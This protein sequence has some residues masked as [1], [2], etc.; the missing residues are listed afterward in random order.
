[1]SVQKRNSWFSRS[2]ISLSWYIRRMLALSRLSLSLSVH[3]HR[4]IRLT[5]KRFPLNFI[6]VFWKSVGEIQVS[7]NSDN[8]SGTLHEDRCTCVVTS[9]W[10]LLIV[11]N[12]ADKVVKKIKTHILCSIPFFRKSCRL[13]DNEEKHDRAWEATDERIIERREGTIC[14]QNS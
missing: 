14:M 8:K 3:P 11:T 2:H 4:K 13:W 9:G 6:K 1:M 7:L 5:M 12:V 10:I